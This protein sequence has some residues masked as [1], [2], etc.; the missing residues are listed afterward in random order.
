MLEGKSQEKEAARAMDE[1]RTWATGQVEVAP[2]YGIR[3][4]QAKRATNALA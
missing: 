4:F 3:Q 1:R 2:R